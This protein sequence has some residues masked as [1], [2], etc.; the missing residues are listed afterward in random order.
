MRH[1]LLIPALFIVLSAAGQS[2]KGEYNRVVTDHWDGHDRSTAVT[3]WH[4]GTIKVTRNLIMIDSAS[5][6][7]QVFTINH[8]DP[9]EDLCYDD[10]SYHAGIQHFTAVMM[11]VE[12]AS[13]IKGYLLYR[14]D[15]KTITDVVF[16][17]DKRTE[18]TYTFNGSN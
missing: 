17:P 7:L 5:D 8:R 15:K 12:G 11:T 13:K 14:D 2:R 1:L 4:N 16:Q 6:K 18:V 3:R 10:T 9:I